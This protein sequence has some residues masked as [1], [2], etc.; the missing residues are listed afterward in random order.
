MFVPLGAQVTE[1]FESFSDGAFTTTGDWTINDGDADQG[2]RTA[3]ILNT[4]LDFSNSAFNINGGSRSLELNLEGTGETDD[5][6]NDFAVFDFSSTSINGSDGD[7]VEFQYLFNK[8]STN[9]FTN[10]GVGGDVSAARPSRTSSAGFVAAVTGGINENRARIWDGSQD[11]T[12]IDIADFNDGTTHLVAGEITL[13]AGGDET[14][15]LWVDPTSTNL[16][17]LTPTASVTADMETT[18]FEALGFFANENGNGT[19]TVDQ[20]Q[21]QVVPEPSTYASIMGV[22]A[23]VGIS[24]LRM[25]RTA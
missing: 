17:T 14:F 23:L 25:R 11:A 15:D 3:E 2:S 10:I 7:V 16:S 24:A 4:G 5:P 22:F 18:S 1:D 20:F 13:N 6:A 9:S 12:N 19:L 21:A 8:D